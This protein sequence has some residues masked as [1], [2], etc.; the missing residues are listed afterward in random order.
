VIEGFKLRIKGTDLAARLKKISERH[1]RKAEEARKKLA[2][3]I[4][5]LSDMTQPADE[6]GGGGYAYTFTAS[7]MLNEIQQA[8]AKADQEQNNVTQESGQAAEA[9]FLSAGVAKAED[10]ELD[11]DEVVR[12]LEPRRKFEDSESA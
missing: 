2:E 6:N 1:E 4:K 3:A 5:K 9:A 12:H 8:R 11:Y 7:G 10:Y